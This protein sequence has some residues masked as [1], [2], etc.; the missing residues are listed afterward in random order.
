MRWQ[1]QLSVNFWK[2]YSSLRCK[3]FEYKNKRN[4]IRTICDLQVNILGRKEKLE[5]SKILFFD[6]FKTLDRAKYNFT[7]DWG[8]KYDCGKIIGLWEPKNVVC[9]EKTN[10]QFLVTPDSGENT[11]YFGTYHYDFKAGYINTQRHFVTEYGWYHAKLKLTHDYYSWPAWWLLGDKQIG[12]ESGIVPEFDIFEEMEGKLSFTMHLDYSSDHLMHSGNQIDFDTRDWFIMSLHWTEKF[13][14]WYVNG[15][16]VKRFSLNNK[17]Y[18]HKPHWMIF[19]EAF[20]GDVSKLTGHDGMILDWV[21]VTDK[22]V[23]FGF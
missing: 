17:S 16:L 6:D 2:I 18:I 7:C 14:D 23:D 13:V 22:N 11:E 19:N 3:L 21:L 1:D 4:K 9:D 12:N 8:N 15:F 10:L 20:K 5:Q